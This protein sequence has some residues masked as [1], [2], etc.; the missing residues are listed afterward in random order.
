MRLTATLLVLA[1]VSTALASA[2]DPKLAQPASTLASVLVNGQPAVAGRLMIR[3]KAEALPSRLASDRA[4]LGD[5]PTLA[6]FAQTRGLRDSRPLILQELDEVAHQSGLDRDI[7]VELAAG[8][9]LER[10]QAAWAARPEVEWA[11]YDWIV[12]TMLVPND[13]YFSGQWGLRNT[14]S[15]GYTNDCDIDAELAWDVYTGSNTVKIAIIDTGVDLNHPDLQ[16][17]IIAGYDYVNND[18]TPDDD[19][20]HGTACASLAAA[21]TNNTSGMAGVDWNARIMPMKVLDSSGSGTDSAIINAINWARTNGA[22]VISMSLGGG[23]NNSTFNTAVN[24]A[25]NAGIPVICAAGNDN[26]S[27]ISYPARYANSFAVGALSPCNTR[28]SPS[29]CDGESWWGSNYGTGLDV[30][31]PG[32]LLRSATINGYITDMNGTSGAT[33]Q[34]AGVAALI[35]GRNSALTAQQIYDIINDTADD[36]GTAGWDSQTGWGRLNAY[37]AVMA[38]LPN[39]CT[40][41]AIP[42]GV[43]HTPLTNTTN[44]STPYPVIAA[45]TDNCTVASVTLRH[46]IGTGAWTSLPM[47]ISAGLYTGSIPA[48]PYG[49]HVNYQIVA[50]DQNS[51]TTTRDH[52]FDVLNPCEL[53][54][55][56]PVLT[57]YEPGGDL[58]SDSQDIEV[59]VNTSDPCGIAD[60]SA[61]YRV[62]GGVDHAV[63]LDNLGG[64][65][66]S[67]LLP[68]QAYGSLVEVTVFS[69]DNSTN[70]NMAEE[71]AS[72]HIVDPCGSDVVE[73]LVEVLTPFPASLEVGQT[74]Q[75]VLAA[76]DPC[77]L[78][79]VTLVCS[80]NGGAQQVGSVVESSPGQFQ[81]VLPAQVLPGSLAWSIA[82]ADDSPQHNTLQLNGGL[83]VLPAAAIGTPQVE[84]TLLSGSQVQLSWVAVPTAAGYR[85][86]S[87]PFLGGPWSLLVDTPLTTISTGA[88]TDQQSIFQVTAHN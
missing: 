23:G 4:Q 14:G 88:G 45:V 41:D 87:S 10:E 83:T 85:V 9:D 73:P 56:A 66:Y 76:T 64:G 48:A 77:G 17:K 20:M 74:G 68:P 58:Y 26:S 84:I 31:S 12:H 47:T 75:M 25:Y 21:I 11:E 51:N 78:Q 62:N 30:M 3:L 28:K 19:H 29:S 36:M 27:T 60:V 43:V 61:V 55:V 7:I 1:V 32:V 6:A 63:Q 33:P 44:N 8:S 65:D 52:F 35:R 69:Y 53:D 49:S 59:L 50:V 70:M 54:L 46:R 81:L 24:N 67:T 18:A 5:A 82:V 15:G 79:G 39:P 16:A 42:P 86:Y 13:Q 40:T 34:V 71:S 22:H 72:L 80:L 37:Q 2:P 57:L 38:A